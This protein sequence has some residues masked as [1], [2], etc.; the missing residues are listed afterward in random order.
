MGIQVGLQP[1]DSLLESNVEFADAVRQAQNLLLGNGVGAHHRT[2]VEETQTAVHLL[3]K[4]G[5]LTDGRTDEALGMIKVLDGDSIK[6]VPEDL[7]K[8]QRNNS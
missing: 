2:D 5:Y 4:C 3:L 8:K 6:E 1:V 7:L